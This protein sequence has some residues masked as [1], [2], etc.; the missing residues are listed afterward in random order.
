MTMGEGALVLGT[1][2]ASITGGVGVVGTTMYADV[3]Q[4]Q[5]VTN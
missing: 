5:M 4:S 2:S 1:Q 3:S